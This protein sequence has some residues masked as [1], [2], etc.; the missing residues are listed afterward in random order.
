[1]RG[2]TRIESSRRSPTASID[3]ATD[4]EERERIQ[5]ELDAAALHAYGLDREQTAFVL[6][7]FHR[8]RDPRRMTDAYFDRVLSAYDAMR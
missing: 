8:V 3:C 5:A 6:K 2:P 4:P 1:L 7:D